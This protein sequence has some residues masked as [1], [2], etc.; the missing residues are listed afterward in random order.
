MAI[1]E[2]G[3]LVLTTSNCGIW[4]PDYQNQIGIIVFKDNKDR[5][6][7]KFMFNDV[8]DIYTSCPHKLDNQFIKIGKINPDNRLLML[9]I[10][11]I[12]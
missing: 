2:T 9:C 6:T 3:D 10:N 12:I 5:I 7:V 8:T 4:I 1:F 11:G